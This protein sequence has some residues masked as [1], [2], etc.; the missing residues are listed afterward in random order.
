MRLENVLEG[1]LKETKWYH[2]SYQ[3]V[4]VVVNSSQ[5]GFRLDMFSLYVL[6]VLG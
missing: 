3:T 4:Y 6:R 2:H 5:Q 1:D